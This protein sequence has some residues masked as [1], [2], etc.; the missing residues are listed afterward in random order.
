MRLHITKPSKAI[1]TTLLMCAAIHV[2]ANAITSED[3]LSIS[4]ALSPL[5]TSTIMDKE[6]KQRLSVEAGYAPGAALALDN[7]VKRWL[8]TKHC[9]SV[10]AQINIQSP[11]S[12]GDDYNQDYN[13]PTLSLGLRV[14]LN[15]GVTMHRLSDTAWG[16]LVPVDYDSQ[17]GNIITLYGKFSRPLWKNQHWQWSYYLGTGLG[18]SHTKYNTTDCID[19]EFIGSHWN[20]FFTAGTFLSYRITPNLNIKGGIDFSH[21]SNGALY[22]PN[23]GFNS[24]GP[25]IALESNLG[26]SKQQE[27][28]KGATEAESH[29]ASTSSFQRYWF[30][31]LSVGGGAKTLLEDWQLTQ[32]HTNPSDPNY[33]TSKFSVY[34]AFSLQTDVMYRYARRW[35]SGLGVDVFYGDYANRIAH[36]D[37]ANG[38]TQEPHSPWS[39]G[40]AM[41]HE[42]Y[43]GNLSARMGVGYYLYRHMGVE[44]KTI[45]KPYYERIG[46]FYTFHKWNC[47]AIGF[48]V[49]AHATKA[50]FTEIELSIPFKLSN[51]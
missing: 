14:N 23:K 33:R 17:L 12:Q 27:G 46:L 44:A 5:S 48:N 24:F 32:F 10:Y 35:A 4:H 22:R 28:D 9:H 18:Y 49:N 51:H 13:D 20:I 8:K 36:L 16:Q 2:E 42:V 11:K 41:K 6:H 34:G 43:Y 21:H 50:D 3:S 1:M 37:A 38:Y 15:H 26:N 30:L 45:E 39:V 19:N 29:S 47:I 7:Y 25:F 40:I 31:E